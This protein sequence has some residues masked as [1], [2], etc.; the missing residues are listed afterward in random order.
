MTKRV[1]VNVVAFEEGGV[2]VA[3]CLEYDIAAF[4]KSLTELPRAL[5]RAVAANLCANADLGRVALEGIP[6]APAH[7]RELFE[8][9]ELDLKPTKPAPHRLPVKIRDLRVAEAA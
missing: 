3:Q 7:Y 6:S 2:W 4:A 5:E 9:A 1:E 8:R